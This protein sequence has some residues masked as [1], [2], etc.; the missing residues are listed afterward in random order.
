MTTIAVWLTNS[1][2]AFPTVWTAESLSSAT[3]DASCYALA[4]GE[5][6]VAVELSYSRRPPQRESASLCPHPSARRDPHYLTITSNRLQQ[7]LI[8]EKGL[9]R[10][11]LAAY[12]SDLQRFQDF[13]QQEE[14]PAF[15]DF[16]PDHI[17]GYLAERRQ[18]GVSARTLAR[19]LV[20]IKTLYRFLLEEGTLAVDPTE[21]ISTPQQ[22]QVLPDVLSLDEVEQ[23]LDAPD[24]DTPLGKRDAA[25]LE[26]LYATG[27][28]VSEL[29]DLSL[30]D[31]HATTGCIKVRGKGGKERLVPMGEVATGRV[32]DYV[33]A[34]RPE[35]AKGRQAA[36][37][38]INRSARGLS[39]QALWKIVKKYVQQ[40]GD[41]QVHQSPYPAPFLCNASPCRGSRPA[42]ASAHARP[43]RYFDHPD[44]YPRCAAAPAGSLY[45]ASSPSIG[46]GVWQPPTPCTKCKGNRIPLHPCWT[47]VLSG[48]NFFKA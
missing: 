42:V 3:V 2:T 36:A 32:E 4:A 37:L 13:V 14:L 24:T 26:V 35:L 33:L 45:G 20:S 30:G 46:P 7:Y 16:T 10:N 43:R 9:S 19:E 11:T 28:R 40:G 31:V 41:S 48:R 18:Q 23:L 15:Q 22:R 8:V 6:H 34:G 38:F 17:T 21:Q 39:R 44:I 25:M 1:W 12:L 27:L 5:G 29:V 47:A